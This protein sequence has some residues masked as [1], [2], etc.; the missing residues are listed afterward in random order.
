MRTLL[1][2]VG[3]R[4]PITF[5]AAA[6]L[7]LGVALLACNLPARQALRVDPMRALRTG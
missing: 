2:G 5:G 7:L 4:D 6:V 3:T 1:F